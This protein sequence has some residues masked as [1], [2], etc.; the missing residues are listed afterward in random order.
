[1]KHTKQIIFSHLQLG[2]LYKVG[3]IDVDNPTLVKLIQI[4]DTGYN[5]LDVNTNKC[6]ISKTCYVNKHGLMWLPKTLRLSRKV[7]L[8][9][10]DSII[11]WERI[12]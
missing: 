10:V 7:E 6:I 8:D 1:M 3:T 2:E 4:S 11:M 5:F 12:C 9:G